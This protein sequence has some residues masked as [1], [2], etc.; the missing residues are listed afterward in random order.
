MYCVLGEKNEKSCTAQLF[1]YLKTYEERENKID[2][3]ISSS[4]RWKT[5]RL[6][7]TC[8]SKH[9]QIQALISAERISAAPRSRVRLLPVGK[10]ICGV[11]IST[12]LE[13][14]AEWQLVKPSTAQGLLSHCPLQ[15]PWGGSIRVAM[16]QAAR[17]GSCSASRCKSCTILHLQSCLWWDSRVRAMGCRDKLWYWGN[18]WLKFRM[19]WKEGAVFGSNS[20]LIWMGKSFCGSCVGIYPR[21]RKYLNS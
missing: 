2:N 3:W 10:L 6:F 7:C 21:D 9:A 11:K 16:G 20:G 14:S 19:H 12:G 8:V 5:P 4:L 17:R 18:L 15:L 1:G 13:Y